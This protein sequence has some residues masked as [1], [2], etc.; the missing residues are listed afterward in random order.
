MTGVSS[1]NTAPF[2]YGPYLRAIPPLPV[3]EAKGSVGIAVLGGGPSTR[4]S[5]TGWIYNVVTGKITANT[6]YTEVDSKGIAYSAY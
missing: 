3:G 1:T 5:A 2:A 4:P 6:K